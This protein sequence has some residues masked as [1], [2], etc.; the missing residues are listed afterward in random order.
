MYTEGTQHKSG[1]SAFYL[2]HYHPRTEEVEERQQEYSCTSKTCILITLIQD[3]SATVVC[4]AESGNGTSSLAFL[5]SMM[6][7]I[8]LA[9]WRI[10]DTGDT[11]AE[12]PNDEWKERGDQIGGSASEDTEGTIS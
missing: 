12:P 1:G 5:L 4:I 7:I 2:Q 8:M 9:W 11:V 10:C 6:S 3:R